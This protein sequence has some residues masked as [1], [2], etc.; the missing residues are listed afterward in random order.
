MKRWLNW[1]GIACFFA[2]PVYCCVVYYNQMTHPEWWNDWQYDWRI[3]GPVA[4]ALVAAWVILVVC[5]GLERWWIARRPGK[6]EP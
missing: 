4:M 3:W 5:W 2:F 1:I 6:R